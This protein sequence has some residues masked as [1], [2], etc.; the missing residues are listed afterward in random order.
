MSLFI[1]YFGIL[2]RWYF[3]ILVISILIVGEIFFFSLNVE[4]D[5]H[6]S[7]GF[8]VLWFLSEQEKK[9]FIATAWF[10]SKKGKFSKVL[11][12]QLG[13][14]RQGCCW[15]QGRGWEVLGSRRSTSGPRPETR[16]EQRCPGELRV[17]EMCRRWVRQGQDMRQGIQVRNREKASI[18]ERTHKSLKILTR[19][20]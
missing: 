18:T 16:Q 6:L 20:E 13:K 5:D 17:K 2:V 3:Y 15:R 4:D 7:S 19:E 1:L 12:G 11:H 8:T 10:S 14:R 9:G